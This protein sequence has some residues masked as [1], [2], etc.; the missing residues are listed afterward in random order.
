MHGRIFW[1]TI[2]ARKTAIIVG[3]GKLERDIADIVDG[4]QFVM[5]FNE[6]N[7]TGGMSG[8]RTDMI[9]L[10]ASSKTL[11]RRMIEPDFL[12][13]KALKAAKVVML[14]Y[15][16][17]IIRQY[18]P[19]PNI[20]QRL[21]GRRADWTMQ[22]IKQLGKAGK[23]IRI[24]P[25]QTYMDGCSELGIAGPYMHQIFPSTGF[26]G[27]AYTLAKFPASEWDVKLCGFSWEGWKRHDWQKERIWVE[28]R[29]ADDR[30]SL[31]T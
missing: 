27:I 31:I 14:A 28:N 9:M 23:E 8:E 3:N 7:L 30:L 10:A 20:F 16:P 11:Y 13:N 25:P 6:P 26:L 5:R 17:E 21:S 19:R 15:H 1:T 2:L 4:A 12:D 22:A 29:I 24:M 18:H